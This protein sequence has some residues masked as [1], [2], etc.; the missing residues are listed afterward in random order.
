MGVRSSLAEKTIRFS[1][2]KYTD[3]QDIDSAIAYIREALK[4]LSDS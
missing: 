3:E 4:E 1:M 2:G